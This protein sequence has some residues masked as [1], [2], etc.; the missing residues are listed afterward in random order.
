MTLSRMPLIRKR[1]PGRSL[2]LSLLGL[3]MLS[4]CAAAPFIIPVAIEFARNLIQTSLQNYGSKHR[5]NLSNLVNR[6]ADPYI[7]NLPPTTMGTPGVPGQSG[8]PG[9]QGIPNQQATSQQQFPG[10]DVY[11]GQ[12]GTG[13][14]D[15]SAMPQQ[16][17]PGHQSYPGQSGSYDP[18][19]PY[20]GAGTPYPGSGSYP[21]G[22]QTNPYG[23]AQTNPGQQGMNSDPNNPYGQPQGNAYGT[24]SPYGQQPAPYAGQGSYGTANPYGSAAPPTASN[25]SPYGGSASQSPQGQANPYGGPT[26]SMSQGGYDPNN[27]YGT[28]G[29]QQGYEQPQ[30][31]YGQAQSVP[32][33]GYNPNNPY[34]TAGATPGAGQPQPGYGQSQPGY[35]QAQQPGQQPYGGGYG[36]SAQQYGSQ[37]YGGGGI[38][39]RSVSSELVAVDVAM[40]KQKKTA[41]GKEVV[42]MNDGEVLKDGGTNPKAGD[43]FKVVVRTN[44]DC[45]LYIV[46]ID[47]SGWAEPIYPSKGAATPEPVKKDQEYA[48]PDGPYWFSLDQVKGIETFYVVASKHPRKDLEESMAQ[49]AEEK[50]PD[51]TIVAKVEEPPVVPRGVGSTRTRG[52]VTVKDEEGQTEKVTPVSYV[53]GDATQDVTVTRWFKHE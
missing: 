31:G 26:A 47:G 27:P 50:R 43:K 36:G 15:Q 1:W 40:V 19:N 32:Q 46:S 14:P 51:T 23:S 4:S 30:P 37:P 44:C 52:I 18:N 21:G 45:Y 9:Q 49:M 8:Y 6:L 33:G 20:G 7:Q 42:L 16:Q 10:Q 11:P 34:G 22:A 12:A 39:P 28:G 48:F 2:F 25:Q 35:G 3:V 13:S 29:A 17:F 5:D 53:A 41:N 38:Y 24:P